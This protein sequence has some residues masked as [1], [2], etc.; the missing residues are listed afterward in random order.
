MSAMPPSTLER[1]RHHDL[2]DQLLSRRPARSLHR[3]GARLHPPQRRRILF[4]SLEPRLLMSADLLPGVTQPAQGG[5][6][7]PDVQLATPASMAPEIRWTAPVSVGDTALFSSSLAGSFDLDNFSS[8]LT[9][10]A[11]FGGLVHAGAV[12]GTLDFETDSDTLSLTLDGQQTFTLRLTPPTGLQARM[13]A[14]DPNGLSLG[15]VEAAHAGDTLLLQ[16]RAAAS[17]GNYSIQVDSLAGA[18]SYTVE[19]FLNA[20]LEEA[21][22]TGPDTAQ[23]LDGVFSA[24]LDSPA[25][26]AAVIGNLSAPLGTRTVAE[27]DFQDAL[28]FNAAQVDGIWQLASSNPDAPA[29][30]VEPGEGT[31]AYLELHSDTAPV[32]TQQEVSNG[33]GG[34][35]LQDYYTYDPALITATWRVNL[36]G[37]T[38]AVLELDHGGYDPQDQYAPSSVFTGS[39]DFDGVAFSV[40]GETWVLAHEFGPAYG[41]GGSNHAVIDLVALATAQGLTLGPDTLI[42]FQMFDAGGTQTSPN[43]YHR[44]IDNIRITTDQPQTLLSPAGYASGQQDAEFFNPLSLL[45]DNQVPREGSDFNGSGSIWWINQEAAPIDSVPTGLEVASG[46]LS[47]LVFGLDFGAARNLTGLL[48]SLDSNDDYAV[49]YSLDGLS[50]TRLVDILSTDGDASYGMDT[51]RLGSAAAG[52]STDPSFQPVLAQYLRFYATGGDGLYAIGE[53]Q[54]FTEGSADQEDWYRLTLNEGERA[55]FTLSLEN[56]QDN[57]TI[58]LALFD[59]DMQLVALGSAVSGQVASA[60]ENLR[61][62][63]AGTYTLRVTGSTAGAYNLVAVKQALFGAASNATQDLTL[64]PILLDALNGTAGAQGEIRVGVVGGGN[65]VSYLSDSTLYPF[66][67]TSVG[68]DQIDTA[69]ELAGFDVLVLGN[70]ID[71]YGLN[72][73]APTLREW[74]ESGHGLVTTGWM[75]YY[76]SLQYGSVSADL[77]ALIPTNQNSYAS[78]T[79]GYPTIDVNGTAH[80]VTEGVANFSSSY[81]YDYVIY[82]YSGVDADATVLGTVSGYPAIVVAEPQ[83]GRTVLLGPDYAGGYNWANGEGDQLLE[84]AVAW[85][86]Q[87]AN[88]YTVQALAGTDLVVTL[89]LLDQDIGQPAQDLA[90]VI[91]IFDAAGTTLLATGTLQASVPVP[92]DAQFS[93]V[94]RG[95][96]AGD[97]LLRVSADLPDLAGA[98]NVTASTLDEAGTLAYFPGQ[99]DITFSA[100]VLFTS[101][102]PEDLLINGVPATGVSVLSPTAVRFTFDSADTGDGDYQLSLAEGSVTDIHGNALQAWGTAFAVDTTGPTVVGTNLV[103]GAIVAPGAQSLQIT[104]SEPIEPNV[105]SQGDFQLLETVSGLEIAISSF[106]YDTGSRTLTLNTAVLSEGMYT[107]TLIS[108]YDSFRDPVGNPLDGDDNG[109]NGGNFTLGFQVDVDTAAYPPMVALQPLGAMVYDPLVVGTIHAAGDIDTYTVNLESGQLLTVVTEVLSSTLQIEIVVRDADDDSIVATL[110]GDAGQSLALQA[111]G[112]LSGNYKVQV[113]G[114]SGSGGYRFTLVLNA[115]VEQELLDGSPNDSAA[116]AVSLEP[117]R[118]AVG[119]TGGDRLAVVGERAQDGTTGD[120][121]YRVHLQAGQAASMALAWSQGGNGDLHL[122]LLAADGTPIAVAGAEVGSPTQGIRDFVATAEG[123]YLLRVSGSAVGQYTLVVTRGLSFQLPTTVGNTQTQDISLTGEVLG[124]LG[125]G[126]STAGGGAGGGATS[127]GLGTNL[128]DAS[129]FLWDIQ[130]DGQISDG[131]SDAYDG[132]MRNTAMNFFNSGLA[133]D[134][135]REILI[136]PSTI[137]GIQLSRKVYVPADQSFA[138]F[139]EIVTNT[140]ATTQNF[141]VPIYTNLGSDGRERFNMTSSG[142][143]VV[144][145]SDNWIITDDNF[146]GSSGGDPVVTHVV[147][148]EGARVRPASFSGG[149]GAGEVRY[150]YNLTLAPGETQIIMHFASQAADQATALARAPELTATRLGTLNGLSAQEKAAIVNFSVDPGNFTVQVNAGDN[151]V[152]TTSTPGD[153][154]GEPGNTLNPELELLDPSGMVVSFDRDGAADGH[155]AV[156]THTALVTGTYAVRVMGT[157]GAGAYV[158]RVAGATGTPAPLTVTGAS[159][160]AGQILTVAPTTVDIDFSGTLLSDSIQAGDLLVNGQAASGVLQVDGNTLRFD[161]SGLVTGDGAYTLEIAAAALTGAS[162][163]DNAA[164][165]RSFF[166]DNTRPT[167]T[168]SSVASGESVAPGARTLVF[169]FSEDL[170]TSGLGAED[171]QLTNTTTGQAYSASSFTYSAATDQLTLQYADLPEGAYTLTLLSGSNALRDLVGN[172]LNGNTATPEADNYLLQFAVDAPTQALP[173]F[174]TVSLAG[175]LIY[176]SEVA[177]RAVHGNGDTDSFTLSLDA[178]QTLT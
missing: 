56:P 88:R 123:D 164:F 134:D 90:P 5:N 130:G 141:T 18:G 14:F 158:L 131:T 153:G 122:S 32:I 69:Q 177:D 48:L 96:G 26:R 125:A 3:R 116:Q 113:H 31:A 105:I 146:A 117:S 2:L 79:Y 171:V 104:F 82:G 49:D 89:D 54:A 21:D 92:A 4:E 23:D 29:Y 1:T 172:A 76:A 12:Q 138:R 22:S 51:F 119:S 47:G 143:A 65:T 147:A 160:Q 42:R 86:S 108:G 27:E 102:Q 46:A 150:S 91:E 111:L 55:S 169:N 135:N 120:D 170:D 87:K 126:G 58:G 174:T 165:T 11:P 43:E 128:F 77:D 67:V 57:A 121:V 70:Y 118:I 39:A 155:N 157:S 63:A 145:T 127:I 98:L 94:V 15:A 110:G 136:G 62:P 106:S 178:G 139:L 9:P 73:L 99:V 78:Y 151:L 144:N 74:V 61:A 129:G 154:P 156:V 24:L 71:N 166:V 6:L 38:S 176:R 83:A 53:A 8:P 81:Y 101:V 97:Y 137:G 133:E 34:T 173:A 17:T 25:T 162:G 132:G 115:L 148:G 33:E 175:S 163:S 50:W 75:Q 28:A 68:Y 161:V 124:Y 10:V 59:A 107:L 142:D 103:D 140:S 41:E 66:S 114:L 36:A 19:L 112:G 40:D 80:P 45:T 44:T 109:T 93:I 159:V 13:E 152:I 37:L 30:R 64:T 7:P 72:Q 167:V 100:P 95:A 84:Q 85:A 60:I 52:G 168:A 20:A 35:F 16:L 149:N